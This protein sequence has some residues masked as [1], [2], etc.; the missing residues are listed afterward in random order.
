M[1]LEGVDDAILAQISQDCHI[2][3]GEIEDVYGCTPFQSGLVADSATY[4]QRFVHSLDPFVNLDRFCAALNQVVTLNQT[5]RT[6]IVDCDLGLVQVVVRKGQSDCV[7]R[8]SHLDLQQY[9][10]HDRSIPMQLA[11]PLARFAIVGGR[12]L[13]TTIHHAVSDH[14]S[15]KF[16]LADTW[17]IYQERAPSQ[18]APFKKFVEYCDAIDDKNATAFWKTQFKGGIPAIFPSVPSDHL[19]K[20]SQKTARDIS[21]TKAPSRPLMPAYIEAAWGMTAADYTGS[22]SVAFGYVMSGRSPTMAGA[23]TTLG[24]TVTTVPMQVD[25]TPGMTIQQLLQSRNRSRRL[26]STSPALQYGMANIRHNV[27]D[28]ARIASGFQAVLNILHQAETGADTPGLTLDEEVDIQRAY[29]LVLTCTLSESGV[30]IKATFDNTVLPEVQMQRVLRQM[31]HHFKALIDS[32]S[33]TQI[34]RLQRLNFGDTLELVDWNRNIPESVN[35]C[36]HDLFASRVTQMPDETAVDAWDGKATYRELENMTNNLARE[37][38]QYDISAEEPIPFALQRSLSMVVAVLGIMKAGG[39]CVPID[40]SLPKARKEAIVNKTRARVVL[41]S[42]THHEEIAG[43]TSHVIA[44]HPESPPTPFETMNSDPVRAAYIMFT[45][46]STGQPKGVVL[47]HRSLASSFSAFGNRV[48]WIRGTRVLQFAAPA[49]DACALEMLGPLIAGGCVCIPSSEAR[50]SALADYINTARVDFAIQTPTALKNLTPAGVLPSL[51]VL[52]SAGEP[53]PRNASKTWGAKMRLFNGW[54]PCETSVCATIAE[55][56]PASTH[57]DTIG[58]PVGSAIWIVDREDPSKLLPIGA[59]GEILVEGPGVA[60]GYHNE[61]TKTAAAFIPPPHFVP[62]R[63]SPDDS[64][65]GRSSPQK[66]YRTGDLA[67]Y[68]PDGSITFIGRLDNQVKMR[69]QRFELGEVEEVLISRRNVQAVAVAAIQSQTR[70][71]KDLVAVLTLSGDSGYSSPLHEHAQTELREVL[72]DTGNYDQ[73]EAIREFAKAR[74]P[75]YMVPTAWVVVNNLPQMASKK[76]DRAKI[77]DWLSGLDM[78]AARD[79]AKGRVSVPSYPRLTPPANAVEE[80]LQHAWSSVLAIET[81]RI[82]RESSFIKLGGDSITAMQVATRCRKQGFRITVAV[83]LRKETL[84]EAATETETLGDVSIIPTLSAAEEALDCS[85]SPIQK[86][87]ADNYGPASNNRFNQAFLLEIDTG[88]TKTVTPS[89]V[90]QALQRLVTQH[91]MLRA[92][93]S[94]SEDS[95]GNAT[96]IQRIIATDAVET[97][98]FRVHDNVDIEGHAQ[99]IIDATQASLDIV[100]GPVFAAD[101]I[102]NREGQTLLFMTAH[103]LVIDLVSWRILWDDLE[104]I[105]HDPECFLSSSLPF[106]LWVKQQ[107]ESMSK[108]TQTV[109]EGRQNMWPKADFD[110]W[111]MQDK[112][113]ITADMRCIRRTLDLEQTSRIMGEACNAPLNT[114]PVM[115]MLTAVI[116]SFQRIFPDRG[117]PALYSEGHGRDFDNASAFDPSRTVGWFTTVMPLVVACVNAATPLEDAVIAVKDCYRSTSA[118]ATGQFTS[119]ILESDSFRRTHVEVLFNFAG[120]LQQVTR[121]DALLK[122]W[123][124]ASVQ[125][126]NTAEDTEN[127]GLLSIL[128]YIDENESLA[129]T[130]DYNRHMAHQDRIALWMQELEAFLVN[131]ATE[132]PKLATRLTL[133]DLPLLKT[134]QNSLAHI[135]ACLA[136]LGVRQENVESIY[137]C[138]AM[139]QGI[140]FAQLKGDLDGNQYRD[141]F[142]FKLTSQKH[143]EVDATR[144]VDAWKAVCEAHPILR[145]IFTSELSGECAFQ[146]I[147]LKHSEPSISI[148]QIPADCSGIIEVLKRQKRPQLAQTQPP[149]RLTLYTGSDPVVYAV[150]DISHTAL[151]ARTMQAIWEQIGRKYSHGG[152]IAKGRGFSDYVAWLQGQESVSQQYWRTYLAGAQPCL[153]PRDAVMEGATYQ[154]RGPE[155]PFKDAHALNAFCQG[156]GVTIANFMQA[157]WGVVL[158]LYTGLSDVYFGYLRSDQDALEG[159]AD[160]LG[161]L[162]SMLVCKFSFADL[163]TTALRMLE[164]AREDAAC[165]LQHSGCSLARLHDDLGLLT[166]PLFDTIMTIQ[167]AWPANLAGGD[168]DLKIEAMDGEDPTEYS[169]SVN[170]HYSKDEMILR[171]SYQGAHFSNS[172]IESVAETFANVIAKMIESPEQALLESLEPEAAAKGPSLQESP[173]VR[174][175]DLSILKSW[176]A[177]TPTA[178]EAC[179]PHRV[180]AV[181]LQ[182]PLAPAVCSWDRNLDY[183]QLDMLSDCLAYRIRAEYGVGPEIIVPFACEKAASAVVILLAISKAG[184]AFLPLDITHSPER[185]TA[186]LDDA[187]ASLVLVNSP[188]LR[189]KMRTCTSQSV[190]LVDLDMIE[191]SLAQ[192]ASKIRMDLESVVVKPSNAA[193]AV[194]TSGS[195][196]KPKGILVDHTN[197]ATSAEEHTRRLGITSE[198]RLLQLSSFTFDVALGDIIYA[199]FS[200]ACLCMPSEIE[201]T[202]DLAGAIMRMKANFLWATPTHVTLLTPEDVPTLQTISLIGEPVKQENIETWAPHVRLVNSYG[203]AEAAVMASC[204]DVAVGDNSQDIGHP[205]CCRFWV[206]NPANHDDLVLTGTTGELII[207]GPLV[208][209]GY[210]NNYKAT[211]AAFIDPPAWTK[212]SEFASL[213]FA[214]Q[215]FYKTGDLVTQAGEMSFIYQ[216]RKDTQIKI[217]GQRIELGEIEYHLNHRAEQGWHWAVEVVQPSPDEDVCLAAFFEVPNLDVAE[218]P[219]STTNDTAY[220]HELLE[221]LTEN[222]SAAKEMLK[223]AVPAYMVPDYFIHLRKLPTTSSMKTDRKFLR[224]MVAS[225]PKADLLAYRVLEIAAHGVQHDTHSIEAGK[226]ATHDEVFMQHAWADVLKL[227]LEAISASDDFFSVGG[228]S[229]RAMHLVARLRKAGHALSVADIF[230]SSTLAG[231]VSN[232]SPMPS[233]SHQPAEDRNLKNTTIVV[234]DAIPSLVKLAEKWTWLKSDNIES[235]APATDTQAW[236]LAVGDIAGHGFDDSVTLKPSPGHALDLPKLQR[237]CQEVI[238]QQAILRTVFVPHDSQLFQVALR[239]PPIEQVHIWQNGRSKDGGELTMPGESDMTKILPHFNM[240][241]SGGSSCQSFE[242]R[243]HHALYDAISLGHLLEDLSTVYAGQTLVARPTHFHEWISHV[244][245][246]ETISAQEF[247]KELLRGSMSHPLT[248]SIRSPVSGNA[249]DSKLRVSVPLANLQTSHGT[250]ATVLRATWSLVLSQVLDKKDIVFG[251]ISANRYSTC[252]PGVDRITGPCINVLPV[253]VRLRSHTTIESFVTELQHQSNDSIPHQ[254]LGFRSIVRDCTRW[255]TSRFNSIVVFQNHES[256]GSLVKLGD[257]ECKFSGEGQV[258]DS[259]DMW[260]TAMP[261]SETRLIIEL[262]YSSANIPLELAHWISGCLEAVLNALPHTWTKTIDQVAEDVCNTMGSCPVSNE[263]RHAAC[264]TS[265][266]PR[267]QNE[268][269]RYY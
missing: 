84:A 92:R 227:P 192:D 198:S 228:N 182:H 184:A 157:A 114:T 116:L 248:S 46:G 32:P 27:S 30:L 154:T 168:G 242:L 202:D 149:H 82:G 246:E 128:V 38:L 224:T 118:N 238:H 217:R 89:H 37:L 219:T 124:H 47:E 141:R 129:F 170:V 112:V 54:G 137:P 265:S 203:P 153:F 139:Q 95:K 253:R 181:A 214:S 204:R 267:M 252:L 63:R 243:I 39:T 18:H 176:N 29:G 165:A 222:A 135:H 66:L 49:W 255:P 44:L 197:I 134:D 175:V 74:L 103:H 52:M 169:I 207:E 120:R 127:V 110:F 259:A 99:H 177:K 269:Q 13:V 43:C 188:T 107:E 22:E 62:K 158:R 229:I 261:Q 104:S 163:T 233:V 57:P 210:I 24:P 73:L 101:V 85:L 190:V 161:P 260:L 245:G 67:K 195:T 87:L 221:P 239:N 48:G 191:E 26:L 65:A 218:V 264:Q 34:K 257:S 147:V 56:N 113:P 179:I 146:Q 126:N 256:L 53:V 199:L 223:R 167:R 6:R 220:G 94:H 249:A 60:R 143:V 106:P 36:L 225:L 71:H 208:A 105:L 109:S 174:S 226:E 209:R 193:Y 45:S 5:L 194:Y 69:G 41:T 230:K 145:T 236:M 250:A 4:I 187:G 50:E 55:L 258:G 148:Q 121:Q 216:G 64:R 25:F 151:D 186:V 1:W 33:S 70:D 237:A 268:H 80:A 140:L 206:V 9:L 173:L 131:L 262:H 16:L 166:S 19:V 3:V 156:Q 117:T 72:L 111:G 2:A 180:R 196:G 91:S 155:V 61:P 234:S 81:D 115:L 96:L 11:T 212:S 102:I 160:I 76:I 132:L 77:R 211:A 68:N 162:T 138:T 159:A 266:V 15:L 28:E 201:R 51:K 183:G 231:M 254:H 78:S 205:S 40:I 31:E 58:T 164:T 240:I 10:R 247:W 14:Y 133:S 35:R 263:R 79:M 232:T 90:E 20:A 185:L 98:R 83:L 88:D 97:W 213:D 42:S 17:S 215:R 93:F 251:Y 59:V 75:T 23:E 122:L 150:L 241:S 108:K 244:S 123:N 21:L 8:P 178:V 136:K 100:Q 12:K 144:V 152:S 86:F 171:L 172:L 7:Y 130:L 142:A 200:G 125:M 189:S 235:V 119:Q